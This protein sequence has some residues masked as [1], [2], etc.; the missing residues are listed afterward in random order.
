MHQVIG[1]ARAEPPIT[2]DG[3]ID[4]VA[5]DTHRG[6]PQGSGGSAVSLRRRCRAYRRRCAITYRS[7]ALFN[8]EHNLFLHLARPRRSRRQGLIDVSVNPK[9]DPIRS[10]RYLVGTMANPVQDP[11]YRHEMAESRA[12]AGRPGIGENQEQE[13]LEAAVQYHRCVASHAR[14]CNAARDWPRGRQACLLKDYATQCGRD[15]DP[16]DSI[17]SAETNG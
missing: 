9:P 13:Q 16:S 11:V 14:G 5:L 2:G 15:R 1:H 3:D 12:H 7:P 8:S 6:A 4:L 10:Y 17:D